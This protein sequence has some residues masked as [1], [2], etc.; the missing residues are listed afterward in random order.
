MNTRRPFL[1]LAIALLAALATGVPVLRQVM[2]FDREAILAG[3]WWRLLTCQLVH[4]SASHLACNLAVLGVFGVIIQRRRYRGFNSLCAAAFLAVAPLV[5][6]WQ[7]RV[8]YFGGLSGLATAAVILV[9]LHGLADADGSRKLCLLALVGVA[10]KAAFEWTTLTSLFASFPN[11]TIIPS[12]LSHLAGA[13]I[14]TV[15]FGC[16]GKTIPAH[17]AAQAHKSSAHEFFS[18]PR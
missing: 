5:L 2:V 8:Q 7:P 10:A 12:P 13:C 11:R 18:V 17:G 4:F 9:A 3:E 15:V 16:C 14:A 6:L 1:L